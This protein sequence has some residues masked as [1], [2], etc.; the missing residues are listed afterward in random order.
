MGGWLSKKI[1]FF[2]ERYGLNYIY[3][4]DS[5]YLP[6][7]GVLYGRPVVEIYEWLETHDTDLIIGIY[8]FSDERMTELSNIPTVKNLYALDFNGRFAIGAD[9]ENDGIYTEKF[10]ADNKDT[11]YDLREKLA[12][13]ESKLQLDAFI[14]QRA[15]GNFRKRH[16]DMPQYFDTDV[17]A[18]TEREVF[19]DCGAYDGDTVQAF[20]QTA[21]NKGYKSIY[22][23][24]ADPQ[25]AEKMRQNLSELSEL[26]VIEKGVYSFTGTL[27]FSAGD[28]DSSAVSDDGIEVP[29]TTLDDALE[30]VDVTLLKMDIEGSELAALQ[31]AQKLIRRCRPKLAICVYHR[32]E[33]LVTIPQY[34]LSLVPEYELYFRSYLDHGTESVIYAVIPK[35][36]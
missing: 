8:K 19:I 6:K 18:F 22:A 7:D 13:E 12:D 27:H 34:I 26:N 17:L 3:A 9:E 35:H 23:F 25:N 21:G 31:G 36:K 16:S 2:L 29:V 1:G 5:A 20:L 33:D 10:L 28:K 30:G 11:L 14:E 4:L 24:E 15:N 32:E